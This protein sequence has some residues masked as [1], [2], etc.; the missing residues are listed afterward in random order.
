MSSYDPERALITRV[1]ETRDLKPVISAK[2][3]APF[4]G[5]V[6]IRDTFDWLTDRYNRFG[7]VPSL[8][9][10]QQHFPDFKP[11]DT[12]DD[13]GLIVQS[14]RE[15]KLYS[16]LQSSVKKVATEARGDPFDALATFKAEA[17]ELSVKF[18]GVGTLDLT[19]SADEIR[20]KC[21]ILRRRKGMLGIPWPWARMNEATRGMRKSGYYAFY[22]DPGTMKTWL[23][24][25]ILYFA[26]KFHDARPILFT[27]EMPAEDMMMRWAAM[28]ACVDYGAFQDGKLS[29]KENRRLDSVLELLE[30]DPPFVVEELDS[31][32]AAGLTEIQAKSQEHNATLI[33]IDGLGDL[34]SNSEWGSWWEINKG[35][36][37]IAKRLRSVIVGSH[38]T[39]RER[40]KGKKYDVEKDKDAGDVALGEALFRYSDGLFR[41]VRTPQ[42]E[43][44]EELMFDSKKIREGKPCRFTVHA[45]P[46]LDFSQKRCDDDESLDFEA[47]EDTL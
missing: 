37:G 12:D 32:G 35:L 25:Y 41:V 18:S 42:N 40:R 13:L 15:K 30:D 44:C 9:L 22:G 5:D 8:D 23:L 2:V 39:N 26:H 43:D 11:E 27:Q 29:K 20:K 6:D 4:F 45:R 3:T 21:R 28:I 1:V 36:K 19:K 14:V 7:K 34:C 17:S 33:G 24:L 10:L 31:T 46:A 38:H 47:D 16:D